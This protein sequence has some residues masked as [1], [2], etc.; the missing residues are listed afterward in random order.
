MYFVGLRW[1]PRNITV[2]GK[3]HS[4]NVFGCIVRKSNGDIPLIIVRDNDWEIAFRDTCAPKRFYN[5][6]ASA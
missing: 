2:C 6:D 1:S 5:K 3:Y 4:S